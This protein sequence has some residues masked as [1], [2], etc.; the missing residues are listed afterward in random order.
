M[1]KVVGKGTHAG[2]VFEQSKIDKFVME[3]GISVMKMKFL[4]ISLHLGV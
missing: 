1:R 4:L 3:S 2:V